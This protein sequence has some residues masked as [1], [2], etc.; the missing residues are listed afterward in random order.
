M[1]FIC[2]TCGKSFWARQ[3]PAKYCSRECYFESR[4]LH[5]KCAQCGQEFKAKRGSQ[6]FCSMACYAASRPHKTCSQ[7]GK[8]F[9]ASKNSVRYCSAQCRK[10]AGWTDR[11]ESKHETLTCVQCGKPFEGYT[12]RKRRFCSRLCASLYAAQKGLCKGQPRKPESYITLTC[13]ICGRSYKRHKFILDDENRNSRFCSV[14][15][16]SIHTSQAYRG[17]GNPHWTGGTLPLSAYGPNWG[18]QNRKA[19]RRDKHTCQVCGYV[20]GGDT[21]L[22]VHHIRPLKEFDG[23]WQTANRLSNLI[24]LCRDCHAAVECGKESLPVR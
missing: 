24:T 17:E 2:Q 23:D 9:L 19:R 6:T 7:C 22:D 4:R 3:Q 15:C 20:S 21:I 12:Y 8:P 10:A 13:E 14:E 11:D 18:R 16:R 5:K 1:D